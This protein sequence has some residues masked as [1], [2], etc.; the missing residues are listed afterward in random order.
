MKLPAAR[1]HDI[2]VSELEKELLVY[3]LAT[4][5]AYCLN[6]TSAI[7]FNACGRNQTF[8]D[9]RREYKFSDDL[10]HFA[11]DELKKQNLIES[12]YSAPF[13]GMNRR[14]VIKRVGL[15]TMF[16]LP[17]INALAVPSAANAASNS[18]CALGGQACTTP[19][20]Q[21]NCCGGLRCFNNNQCAACVTSGANYDIQSSVAAC[22]SS[23]AKGL[24][25]NTTSSA[26]YDGLFCYCP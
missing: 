5:K 20:S 7:V 16:A 24:C 3:D 1:N 26:T 9:L 21:S 13:A 15:G 17:I 6:E 22:N 25:C 18:N 19:N 10:I 14:E 11:L 12:D 2:V 4:N 8:D 23:A